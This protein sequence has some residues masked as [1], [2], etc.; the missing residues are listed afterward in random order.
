M[1][2]PF[3]ATKTFSTED[4]DRMLKLADQFFHNWSETAQ[5]SH[6]P[7]NI[8]EALAASAEWKAIRPLFAAAPDMRKALKRCRQHVIDATLAHADDDMSGRLALD[9]LDAAVE[10][11]GAA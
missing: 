1:E 3:S 5:E 7:E 11:A 6:D 2:N 9:A 4:A 10:K 8:S